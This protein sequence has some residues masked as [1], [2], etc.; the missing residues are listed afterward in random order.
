MKCNDC[1]INLLLAKLYF[2]LYNYSFAL[3][4]IHK[5]DVAKEAS[6]IHRLNYKYKIKFEEE[7]FVDLILKEFLNSSQN[8]K[9]II[10]EYCHVNRN[11][12]IYISS[13]KNNIKIYRRAI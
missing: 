5:N 11:K 1:Y 13:F 7:F 2:L 12:T 3:K 9:C 10:L 8:F 6:K 4:L